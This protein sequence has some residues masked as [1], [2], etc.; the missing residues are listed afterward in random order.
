MTEQERLDVICQAYQTLFDNW[1]E[2]GSFGR[3]V[4]RLGFQGKGLGAWEQIQCSGALTLNNALAVDDEA[5][6]TKL[7]KHAEELQKAVHERDNIIHDLLIDSEALR[8][9]EQQGIRR[10]L[11]ILRKL[12]GNAL[13][14]ERNADVGYA[15]DT[16]IGRIQMTNMAIDCILAM[17]GLEQGTSLPPEKEDYHGFIMRKE[18]S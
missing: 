1:V 10:C 8:L 15:R 17:G 18:N 5:A 11:D 16:A 14:D 4:E 13:L 12:R 7:G 2:G 9:G 6:F 3:L